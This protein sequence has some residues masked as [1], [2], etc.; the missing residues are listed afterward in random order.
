MAAQEQHGLTPL[1]DASS[2]G[3]LHV[4]RFLVEHSANAVAN[5]VVSRCSE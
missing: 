1:H 3:H 4:L 5:V 2:N